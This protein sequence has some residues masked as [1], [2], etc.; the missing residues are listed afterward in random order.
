MQGAFEKSTR[1]CTEELQVKPTRKMEGGTPYSDRIKHEFEPDILM[2][3]SLNAMGGGEKSIC[4]PNLQQVSVIE[5]Y[6]MQLINGV[7]II[8]FQ[9]LETLS[10]SGLII[11]NTS[12][13]SF[14][15]NHELSS[16][17]SQSR[18]LLSSLAAVSYADPTHYHSKSDPFDL[19]L[20]FDS[21]VLL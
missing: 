13:V 18:S 14:S 21:A 19:K 11:E 9:V 15:I 20:I 17:K 4:F 2:L 16:S 7:F 5:I 12:H 8:L 1:S 10:V 3:A 6:S